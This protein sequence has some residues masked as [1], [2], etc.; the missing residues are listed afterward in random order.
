MAAQCPHI[1]RFGDGG[2]LKFRVHI[3]IILFDAVLQRI[4]EECI[5]FGRF[6]TGEG[7]IKI[8][9]LQIGNQQ[10]Q[11][12]LV[13]FTGYFIECYIECF[14]LVF[15]HFDNNAVDLVYAHVN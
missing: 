2:L 12:V 5:D 10:C 13:P 1:A 15:V 11:F 9:T 8:R 7:Y 3:E 6:K 14:F 4:L